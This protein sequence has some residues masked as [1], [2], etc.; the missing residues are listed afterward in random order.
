MHKAIFTD[1]LGKPL[2]IVATTA[3]A[4][5]YAGLESLAYVHDVATCLAKHPVD[6][7]VFEQPEDGVLQ[8]RSAGYFLDE[9]RRGKLDETTILL[10]DESLPIKKFYFKIDD[11]GTFWSGTFLF[12]EEY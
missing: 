12:P 4:A 11:Q 1:L 2:K 9:A 5:E 10:K 3:W 6:M 8:V 7:L